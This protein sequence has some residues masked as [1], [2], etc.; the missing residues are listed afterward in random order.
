MLG[1]APRRRMMNGMKA[2][3]DTIAKD[4]VAPIRPFQTDPT[5]SRSR[6]RDR[7]GAMPLS[8]T[9]TIAMLAIVA[10][11]PTHRRAGTATL[12]ADDGTAGLT[13]GTDYFCKHQT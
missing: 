6:L 13:L 8:K 10:A 4:G 7:S 2:L 5:P 3:T 9:P 11:N 1:A 12:S